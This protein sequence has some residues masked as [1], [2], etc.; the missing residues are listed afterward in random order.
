M[1][2]VGRSRP[3]LSQMPSSYMF[4]VIPHRKTY[5]ILGPHKLSN[6]GRVQLRRPV[7]DLFIVLWS[8]YSDVIILLLLKSELF[9]K[10]FVL[11]NRYGTD[12]SKVLMINKIRWFTCWKGNLEIVSKGWILLSIYILPVFILF[13][14][15]WLV[16][17]GF[18]YKMCS[19]LQTEILSTRC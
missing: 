18:L 13:E 8:K 12:R 11:S 14:N 17:L 9:F 19:L 7:S 6:L 16:V 4:A 1:L 3:V 10:S 15:L 5:V 2:S